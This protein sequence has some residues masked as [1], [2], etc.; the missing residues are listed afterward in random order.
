MADFLADTFISLLLSLSRV[1]AYSLLAVGIVAIYRASKVL[2]L[3]HGTM[4]LV[5][6]YVALSAS[7]WGLPVPVALVAGVAA[8]AALG[9]GVERIF[10]RPLRGESE[11]AQTVGTVAAFGLVLALSVRVWG[12]TPQPALQI[13][14]DEDLRIAGSSIRLGELGLFLVMAVVTA[15]LF[16]V[17]KYT[18]IG[19]I[20]RG[21]AENRRAA[22][23]MGVNP[24]RVTNLAWMLGGALAG[25]AGILLAAVTTLDPYVLSLQALPAFVAA[26]IGGL[27]SFPLAVAGGAAVGLA[28]GFVPQVPVVGDMQGAQELALAVVAIA[29]MAY[30]GGGGLAMADMRAGGR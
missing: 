5:P 4:A 9:L 17:F 12:A 7:E 13:F 6:A 28:Y 10:V 24:Q 19:L 20:M 23:L 3:A 22:A 1:G 14:P 18:D 29:A 8:G 27:Q 15:A 11:T 25:L 30:R 2:N 16:A 26:L 21:T